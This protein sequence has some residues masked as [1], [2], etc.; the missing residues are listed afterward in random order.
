MLLVGFTSEVY[1]I[2]YGCLTYIRDFSYEENL[3]FENI[4]EIVDVIE[5]LFLLV[6]YDDSG[7]KQQE[8][9]AILQCTIRLCKVSPAL[10]HQFVEV[11]AL[12]LFQSG[13]ESV[14]NLQ[15]AAP[16]LVLLI[17]NINFIRLL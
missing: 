13:T 9:K 4:S 2:L 17:Y 12:R 8:L 7:R 3:P 1:D 15:I 6:T 11:I 5:S 14:A 16:S 10:S